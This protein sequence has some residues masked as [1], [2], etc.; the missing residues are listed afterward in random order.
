VAGDLKVAQR[1]PFRHLCPLFGRFRRSGSVRCGR[2]PLRVPVPPASAGSPVGCRRRRG[3][4][5]E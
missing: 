2:G 3:S 4:F 5:P 1:N